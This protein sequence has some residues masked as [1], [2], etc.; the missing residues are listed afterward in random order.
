M[1]VELKRQMREAGCRIERSTDMAL[2][3]G[4][5]DDAN[6]ECEFVVSPPTVDRH[7]TLFL[8]SAWTKRLH[9]Y[10]SNPCVL[11]NHAG[12]DGQPTDVL[13]RAVSLMVDEKEGLIA[14]VRFAVEAN[15]NAMLVWSLLRGGYLRAVSHHFG[16]YGVVFDDDNEE[17]INTLPDWARQILMDKSNHCWACFTDVELREISVVMLPSS[18]EA[19]VRA[20]AD[21]EIPWETAARA[22]LGNSRTDKP[23][24]KKEEASNMDRSEEILA[25]LKALR[26]EV[27]ELKSAPQLEP[28]A[29]TIEVAIDQQIR[30]EVEEPLT[31]ER[32]VA[33]SVEDL[34][35]MLFPA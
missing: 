13:G 25:E 17:L 3:A 24:A 34:A 2:R 22:V 11:W 7:E 23:K 5:F 12:W 8:P 14:R 30:V 35:H 31:G 1:S 6:Y 9:V 27:A 21:G 33:M 19:L 20:A 29:A 32:L 16:V 15:P 26:S 28:I 10:E 4:S 18:R